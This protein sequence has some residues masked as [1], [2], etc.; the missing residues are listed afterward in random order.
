MPVTPQM[1]TGTSL[2]LLHFCIEGAT[3]RRNV[4]TASFPVHMKEDANGSY[5]I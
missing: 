4:R 1:V 3:L 5:L 2:C